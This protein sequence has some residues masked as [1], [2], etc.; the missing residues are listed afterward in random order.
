M[1]CTDCPR[2][3]LFVADWMDV[4]FVHFRVEA[5]ALARSVPFELDCFGGGAYVSLVAFTQQRLRPVFGGRLSEWLAAPLARHEF[6]NV[7]KYVHHDGARGIFFLAEWIPNRLATWIG[8]RTYGLPY[9]LGKLQYDDAWRRV[10]AGNRELVIRVKPLENA[11][12]QALDEFLLERYTAFTHRGGVTRRFDV[13][14]APWR[15]RRIEATVV[16]SS[17]LELTGGWWRGAELVS[18][19]YSAG[20]RDVRMSAPT[21]LRARPRPAETSKSLP[22]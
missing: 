22:A 21:R 2:P 10:N 12:S 15:Q 13:A 4:V 16:E 17:L 18:A 19:N 5:A 9:R 8:P 7:R 3:P 20:V 14:H 6:L 11:D 1:S